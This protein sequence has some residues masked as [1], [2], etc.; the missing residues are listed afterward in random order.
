ML[1]REI[2]L[3]LSILMIFSSN[4]VA[5]AMED[6]SMLSSQEATEESK[7]I[8]EE[9]D[10]SDTEATE[11]IIVTDDNKEENQVT[12]KDKL[13]DL[14]KMSNMDKSVELEK[15]LDTDNEENS[16]V[17]NLDEQDDPQFGRENGYIDQ[18]L[19]ES[20]AISDNPQYTHDNRFDHHTI[21][22]VIDVSKYQGNIDW[23]KV[24]QS[25]IDYAMIRVGFR[26]YGEQGT[27]NLDT[28]FVTNMEKA[29]E[30]GIKVGVYFFSQAISE[31]EAV[32][33]A[34]Y[35]LQNIEHYRISL[36]VTID[37]EYASSNE[38]LIG[39][40][41]NA[42]LSKEQS[43]RICQAFCETIKNAGY[44][45]MVYANKS[46]L[47]DGLNASEL[48]NSY[49]IWVANYSYSNSYTGNYSFWQY[50]Q[51]GAVD[52]VTKNVD[53]SFWYVENEVTYAEPE[54]G[55]YT[56]N[57]C[58]NVSKVIDI[59]S[60]SLTAG[61]GAQLYESNGT[62]AQKFYIRQET[63]DTYVIMSA[64]SGK[65]LEAADDTFTNGTSICQNDYTGNKNQQWRFRLNEDGSY[66]IESDRF[67]M[68][69]DVKY[70]SA[71]NGTKIHLYESNGS[72]A[73][74]FVLKKQNDQDI[75]LITDG[76]Y[77]LETALA[78]E[79]LVSVAANLSEL[80]IRTFDLSN[81]QKFQI[82][83]SG[84]GCYTLTA[85]VSGQYITAGTD[86]K[87]FLADQD[88][89]QEQKWIIKSCGSNRFCL[90][91]AKDGNN[92]DIHFAETK[93]GTLIQKYTGNG[94]AAQKFT[95]Y[96]VS[97]TDKTLED[98]IYIIHSALN[99]K[100][101][102]DVKNG[103]KDCDANIQLYTSNG[104]N[105]QK[106]VLKRLEDGSYRIT[107]YN[108][109]MAMSLQD[110]K[111]ANG[112]NVLQYFPVGTD[113]QKW[114]LSTDLNGYYTIT[115]VLSGK[116][117]DV[118]NASTADGANIQIY[119]SNYSKAQK[120]RF[121][122]IGNYTDSEKTLD[123]GTYV[124][125]SAVNTAKVVDV[126]DGSLYAGAN[127]Q[128]YTANNT[129]DQCF[130]F[131]KDMQSGYYTIT[132]KKSGLSL[133]YENGCLQNDVNVCQDSILGA[134]GSQWKI[135]NIVGDY[136]MIYAGDSDFCLDI[137][138]GEMIDK[139]NIQIYQENGSKAQI[140]KLKKINGE[141]STE[142]T[143]DV[144][145]KEGIYTIYSAVGS[146]M[147]ADVA[148]GSLNHG[149][150]IQLYK[151]N[152]TDAQKFLIR[153]MEN[154]NY[155]MMSLN[156]G[157]MISVQNNNSYDGANVC[158]EDISQEE[159]QQWKIVPAGNGYYQ[160]LESKCG[161]AL[162]VRW[163]ES[164]N[165]TNIQVYTSNSSSAQRFRFT[166]VTGGTAAAKLDANG[167]A[168]QYK[169]FINKMV[170]SADEF[171]YLMRVNSWQKK[172]TSLPVAKVE[173]N[174][175]V[176]ITV[177][178][179]SKELLRELV[180]DKLVLAVKTSSGTYQ[181]VNDP[182]A[183]SNPEAL[184]V[185]TSAIF[186]ASSKK[187]LQGINY[188]SYEGGSD[189]T[190]AR[191]ANTKQTLINLDLASVVSATPKEGYPAYSY[192]GNIYYFSD[193]TDLRASVASLNRGYK[194]YMYGNSETTQVAVTMNLLLS[195][196]SET[197][198]LIDPAAR[199]PGH[200]YYTL[201]VR[202][203][204]ACETFEALF[205]YLGEIFG[206][207]SCYVTNW[208][209]GN[210]INSSYAWNYSGNLDFDTYMDCYTT[211]FRLLY[212][213]VKAQK[214]GNT[215]SI[216]LDN[217]WTVASDT[218]AGKIV[219]DSFAR[220]I[221]D[222]NPNIKW[223]I[224]YHP[225]SAPLTRVDFWNDY[226]NTTDYLSTPYISMR[227]ITVL[228]SYAATM[229]NTY[230]L[231]SGS[232]RVL[233]TE[234]GYSYSGGEENQA[235]AI[236]RSYYTAE[237]N[238]RIDAFIIRAVLDDRDETSEK[239]YLGLMNSQQDKRTAFY[240]YEYMDTNVDDFYNT[241]AE[242]IVTTENY[243]RFHAAKNIV[244]GTNWKACVPGYNKTKLAGMK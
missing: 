46:M 25:G 105:A 71:Q 229:E 108:S 57:T 56:I 175:E 237:F 230:G 172:I 85:L 211:A 104:T 207:S 162:D 34:E 208:I 198:Y 226:S 176:T 185:N 112:T 66:S 127:V 220:K 74:K 169:T 26:G 37:F 140:F 45:P 190:D 188:A 121:E 141:I 193:L 103:S 243:R 118:K 161:R 143:L 44:D 80:E 184:A 173:K 23:Q 195:Y 109:G 42:N 217:G 102:I 202:E 5:F 54:E 201:N 92:L 244:C 238:D 223:S 183:I 27:L 151:S 116:V 139:T 180:M 99:D 94:S 133:A 189:I 124:I 39:R 222:Q 128:L 83:Y 110:R 123:N 196:R 166:S 135:R 209:L 178:N 115:S 134:S 241:S 111:I 145:L 16:E 38:G 51:N 21:Y 149:A 194:Q 7:K 125:C 11:V 212:N 157:K 156:S 204:R 147:V 106:F 240:V 41:Y 216:S 101:V 58:L 84:T 191:N 65:V 236:A 76:C 81:K 130:V 60:A 61:V 86:T 239:L 213:G 219:L 182:V 36:P 98:G 97:E 78:Q 28:S 2:C 24:K 144:D 35:V 232:I 221:H 122:K 138:W 63:E 197:S 96:K 69:L 117:V 174:F 119:Q 90:I 67:N 155:T 150:N 165:G 205:F 242:E 153:K 8:M 129:S 15:T 164:A 1:K 186:K 146:S 19:S 33:E 234:Q 132:S 100:K 9:S 170:D 168:I 235:Y 152:G 79:K 47:T 68:V 179:L 12:D 62:W 14:K 114:K 160:L 120:F 87:V 82:R 95:F 136:Y 20:T 163:G 199:T 200:A 49:E 10:A 18:E 233:C 177:N 31:E 206:Q 72:K 75:Q 29:I 126:A 53:K 203:E 6:T 154:G 231:P 171:Y 30:A 224:A 73:Q 137:R 43:T 107:S 89:S 142:K 218:Y 93:E 187:G 4:T 148:S 50:T 52:G 158:Q 215:V 113:E 77:S 17:I 59:P 32:A 91:S 214:T 210:E 181:I 228:T 192:K 40:L 167:Q 225:Y 131:K 3:L 13:I 70:A 64:N 22:D 48:S 227:N 159:G 88:N 55:I